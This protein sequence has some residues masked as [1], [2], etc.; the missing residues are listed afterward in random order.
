MIKVVTEINRIAPVTTKTFI[1]VN[2]KEN[3]SSKVSHS[4]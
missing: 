2:F 1:K 3:V 4:K